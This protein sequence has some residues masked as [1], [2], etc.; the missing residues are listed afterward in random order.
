MGRM[1]HLC[2]P[3]MHEEHLADLKNIEEEIVAKGEE[4]G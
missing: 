3:S 4:L 2:E 1:S